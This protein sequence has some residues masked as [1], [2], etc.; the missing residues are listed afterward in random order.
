MKLDKFRIRFGGVGEW[1]ERRWAMQKT[2][3]VASAVA[4]CGVALALGV[5]GTVS[6]A[7][8]AQPVLPT[9]DKPAAILVWPKVVVDTSD[10]LSTST[11]STDTLIQLSSV[12][13][14]TGSATL[15]IAGVKQA[16][17]FYVNATG[18]CSNGAGTGCLSSDD[19]AIGTTIGVCTPGWSETDF[20]VRLTPEQ[21][22][23]WLASDGLRNLPL[24]KP[25]FCSNNGAIVC[26]SDNQCGGFTCVLQASNAGSGVPPTPED[27]FVGSLTC[28]QF[29]PTTNPADPDTTPSAN[30]L[31]GNASIEVVLNPDGDL[32]IQK[33]NAIG[34]QKLCTFPPSA[35]AVCTLGASTSGGILQLGG[36]NAA[37]QGCPARLVLN[38]FFDGAEDPIGAG[39][40]LTSTD[41]TLVP[42]GNN[43]LTQTPGQV[44]AQFLV[45]NEF[46]QRFST[47]T[48]VNCFYESEISN[49][50]TPDSGRS[51]FS[52][53][54]AGTLAGQTIIRGVGSSST[55]N[56]LLGVARVFIG[57]NGAA[58]NLNERGTSTTPDIIT[59]P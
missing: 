44:T 24:S 13:P 48:N 12:V 51:I 34:I 38:H 18:H 11:G 35:P 41:L 50:D 29:D 14:T 39:N 59:V 10:N 2:R 26:N 17:C 23:A 36:G 52:F 37:Y 47:S 49:I 6:A 25:G 19:C 28:I 55:G 45:F 20:D 31:I 33:Y 30:S 58:Y 15:N 42:C 27:P 7:H 21:P 9:S 8:A 40:G 5:L 3:R 56:G 46:E 43:F 57:D 54:V 16:H 32:D 22:L 4:G 53:N 1:N